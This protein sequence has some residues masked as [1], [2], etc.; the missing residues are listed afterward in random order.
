MNHIETIFNVVVEMIEIQY[1]GLRYQK[2]SPSTTVFD[3]LNVIDYF[4][5]LLDNNGFLE[6]RFM[7]THV[8]IRPLH[9]VNSCSIEYADPNFIGKI[10]GRIFDRYAARPIDPV[11]TVGM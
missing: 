1:P 9:Y 3:H 7:D 4:T 6:I 5:I 2:Y 8:E 10:C 11:F